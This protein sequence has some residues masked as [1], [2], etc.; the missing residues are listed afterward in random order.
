MN[1]VG[2]QP[3]PRHGLLLAASARSGVEQV[4]QLRLE[5][6]LVMYSDVIYRR[7]Q[8]S[9]LSH[10]KMIKFSW[11]ATKKITEIQSQCACLSIGDRP[12]EVADVKWSRRARC[13]CLCMDPVQPGIF[14]RPVHCQTIGPV[15]HNTGLKW[16][17]KNAQKIQ[18]LPVD[19]LVEIGGLNQLLYWGFWQLMSHDDVMV[20][21][22]LGNKDWT[23]LD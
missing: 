1:H 23:Q 2:S 5:M 8:W 22:L 16:M 6:D 18:L 11:P 17:I 3:A 12:M 4:Q 15:W 7:D 9:V 14:Q 10:S 19:W 20:G 13:R 21:R